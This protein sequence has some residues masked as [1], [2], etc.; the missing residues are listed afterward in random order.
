M[1][2]E[3]FFKSDFD[4]NRMSLIGANLR[5]DWVERKTLFVIRRHD[6]GQFFIREN[7]AALRRLASKS[8]T[9]AQPFCLKPNDR[10]GLL[11]QNEA[12]IC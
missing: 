1:A 4:P 9:A 8:A 10:L 6:F 3:F 12:E 2:A 11:T 5:F 7:I